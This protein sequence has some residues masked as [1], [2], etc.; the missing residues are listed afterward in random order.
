VTTIVNYSSLGNI[1]E[2]T[3]TTASHNETSEDIL[4]GIFLSDLN[5]KILQIATTYQNLPT[6]PLSTPTRP[7]WHRTQYHRWQIYREDIL[8]L[9]CLH[10]LYRVS[11]EGMAEALQEGYL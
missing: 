1:G 6:L 7:S 9:L 5:I 4:V 11:A 3:Y 2:C 10:D 8:D